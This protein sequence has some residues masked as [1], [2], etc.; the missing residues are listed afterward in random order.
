M[1]GNLKYEDRNFKWCCDQPQNA[2]MQA[3]GTNL[4]AT[5]ILT[6]KCTN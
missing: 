4:I 6:V 3:V 2:N 5:L 1:S